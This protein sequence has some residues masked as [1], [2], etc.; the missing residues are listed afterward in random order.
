M[1]TKS[2]RALQDLP[3]RSLGKALLGVS[4]TSPYRCS[5]A[6]G[7]LTYLGQSD[8]HSVLAACYTVQS[9]CVCAAYISGHPTAQG[10]IVS[11]LM[12]DQCM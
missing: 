7:A 12:P 8:E 9:V 6:F 10:D 2:C 4:E 11:L 3:L 1:S 5:G